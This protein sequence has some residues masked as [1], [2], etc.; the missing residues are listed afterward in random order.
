MEW[1][2]AWVVQWDQD[3]RATCYNIHVELSYQTEPMGASQTIYL[4]TIII[5]YSPC[6]L[7]YGQGFSKYLIFFEKNYNFNISFSLPPSSW[8]RILKGS[9]FLIKKYFQN[10]QLFMFCDMMYE[11]ECMLI[12]KYRGTNHL[13]CTKVSKFSKLN[14]L[15][16]H[17][18]YT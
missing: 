15:Y 6:H 1:C 8:S 3:Y 5:F 2:K 11:D 12:H 4:I 9:Y 16:K 18:R 13:S 14:N 10:S 7:T 17:P